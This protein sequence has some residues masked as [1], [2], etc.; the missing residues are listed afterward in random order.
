MKMRKKPAMV[1]SFALGSILFA[2]TALAEVNSK[3]GYVQMKDALKYTAEGFSTKL[4]SYTSERSIIIK[5]NGKIISS[6]N[7]LVKFDV[8][9][10]AEESKTT[11]I[12][13]SNPKV[14]NYYYSDKNTSIQYNSQ[15][16]QYYVQ[17]YEGEGNRANFTN[18]F[19]EKSAGDM[20]RIA[21]A[22]VGNLK[23]SVVV[24]ENAD[25]TKQLSA[26]ISEA[27]IPAV[28]NALVSYTFK[29]RYGNINMDAKIGA[30]GVMSKISEDI[31][32]K[33]IK[34]SMTLNKDGLIQ[35]VMATGVLSGKD[36]KG[37]E[38][39]LTLELLVKISDVNKTVV[40]K[41][42]L[43]GK[44]VET[45]TIRDEKDMYK[46]SKPEMYVGTYKNDI[47]IEKDGKFQKIGERIID[48]TAVND[49]S[50]VGRYHEEYVK[51]NEK[52]SS[53]A[54]DFKF[55]TIFKGN[56]NSEF[57]TTDTLGNKINGSIIISQ[58][59]SDIMLYIQQ[60]SKDEIKNSNGFKRVFN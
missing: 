4:S 59:F 19:K 25:G 28:A 29:S 33:E 26:A 15:Q 49:K 46:I 5:D 47:I 7:Q 44:K 9:K 13:D 20:E 53:T 27:Q 10:G 22:I 39:K 45:N 14:E 12:N 37:V 40:T 54:R 3:S 17:Q 52:Y 8:K 57:D 43:T 60:S 41:P 16:D 56:T 1:L 2:T 21:D 32:V 35:S 36:E 11:S 34:G 51:G 6:D 55:T 24:T 23:D 18:P 48:L 50:I 30:R 38:H 42:D 58:G 31:F